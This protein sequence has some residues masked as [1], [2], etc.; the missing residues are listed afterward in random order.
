M[1]GE[2]LLS[3]SLQASPAGLADGLSSTF[4]LVVWRDVA[5]A[6]VEAQR[7]VLRAHPAQLD[8]EQVRLGDVLADSRD[9]RNDSVSQ[10]PCLDS[11]GR[12]RGTSSEC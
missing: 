5:D 3:G 12:L 6:F 10:R 8:L 2:P 1:V 9:P 11:I 4:V 7:V